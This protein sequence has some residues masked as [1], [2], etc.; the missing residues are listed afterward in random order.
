MKSQNAYWDCKDDSSEQA[1]FVS[2]FVSGHQ[3]PE[4]RPNMLCFAY[5]EL[6]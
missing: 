5:V 3:Q 4:F 6:P 1:S 2:D